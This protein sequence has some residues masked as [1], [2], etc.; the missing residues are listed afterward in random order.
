MEQWN[1]PAFA[2]AWI[3]ENTAGPHS[4][5]REEQLDL[6]IALL[7]AHLAATSAPPHILD[8]GCG[9]GLVAERVLRQ[10]DGATVVGVDASPP[11]LAMARERLAPYSGRVILAQADF[12]TMTADQLPERPYGAAFAVQ[13]IHNIHDEGKRRTYASIRAALAPGGLFVLSDRIRLATPTLFP[14]YL[15]LWDQLNA[16]Y[17]AAGHAW[18]HDEGRTYPTHDQSVTERGDL[19][20]SLEQNL[21]WLREAGFAEVAA[22]QV[23]GI[24]AIIVA[25]APAS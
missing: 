11:M 13:A 25:A 15:A 9:A 22:V 6:L 19:P 5:L 3:E 14:A 4:P 24:R 10:I 21:L 20:G 23:V 1:D 17:A 18:R 8:V 2:R 16:Q 7:R 12:A